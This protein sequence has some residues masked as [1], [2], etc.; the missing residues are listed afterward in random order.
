[1]KSLEFNNELSRHSAL[2]TQD[3]ELWF[4]TKKGIAVVD[5]GKIRKNKVKP[6]VVIE[7]AIFDQ[8]SIAFPQEAETYIIKG[9]GDFTFQFTAPTF[10]SP[11][12]IKFKYQL[13][14][15]DRE[16]LFI[17]PG[18]DRA[19]HYRDLDPGTYTFRVTAC[20]AEGVWNQTGTAV[21]FTLEPFFY[22]TLIFKIAVVLSRA[23]FQRSATAPYSRSARCRS[24]EGIISN[25]KE[26]RR[27]NTHNQ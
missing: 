21:T 10:L 16:W 5:P 12:K 1:L 15:F 18:K 3:H 8:N 17:L 4:I 6:T 25:L 20:S 23:S 9:I 19:A 11:G 7:T 13:E 24:F 27:A 26:G 14:G 22:Q 2:K